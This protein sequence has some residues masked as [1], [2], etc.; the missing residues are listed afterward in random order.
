MASVTSSAKTA[1]TQSVTL[2]T[3]IT[4]GLEECRKKVQTI[5]TSS[6]CG[7]CDTY[8]CKAHRQPEDHECTFDYKK[9]GRDLLEQELTK[10]F[11][12]KL[13]LSSASGGPNTA[14]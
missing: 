10:V 3:K 11:A 6:N 12:T 5:Y 9:A 8:Y 14:H 4:C 13:C 1:Q 7:G 2:P